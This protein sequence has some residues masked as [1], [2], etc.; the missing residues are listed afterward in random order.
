MKRILSLGL[1]LSFT[2]SSTSSFAQIKAEKLESLPTAA[3]VKKEA[4]P[5]AP[6]AKKELKEPVKESVV[7]P[8]KE[9]KD[10]DILKGL[11]YPELQVVPRASDRLLMETQNER[12]YGWIAF[13]PY[14]VSSLATLAAGNRL[15]GSYRDGNMTEIEKQ[16][17]NNMALT[18]MAVG[19][20]GIG[21]S[22]FLIRS[23][24]YGDSFRRIKAY[25]VTDKRSE[26]FRE[27]LSEEALEK[28]AHLINMLTTI[29]VSMNLLA[30]LGV[31]AYSNVDT[32][33]Y[34]LVG[35]ATAFLPWM[36]SNR[37]V[38]N[39]NKQLEYKR[40]IYTPLIGMDYQFIPKTQ[41]LQPQLTMNWSF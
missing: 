12:E 27:R 35:M 40:K 14:Q 29:S 4:P 2:I 22:I 28:P 1:A 30:N 7:I 39:W 9:S 20:G 31:L 21:L 17:S 10:E 25:K 34:A 15:R 5:A 33:S 24:L 32:R 41:Q 11:D 36:F 8:P 3:P 26:L 23:D 38:D 37:Y 16:D 13:W 19:V 18:A 6:A